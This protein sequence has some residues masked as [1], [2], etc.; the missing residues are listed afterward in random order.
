MKVCQA[1]INVAK[2]LNVT[3]IATGVDD[4]A[5]RRILLQLG[6]QEGLGDLYTEPGSNLAATAAAA[7]LTLGV[8]AS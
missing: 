7:E 6:C 5:R 1:A 2:A 8:K 3:A 4:E